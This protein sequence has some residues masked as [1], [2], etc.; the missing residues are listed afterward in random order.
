MGGGQPCGCEGC[1]AQGVRRGAGGAGASDPIIP[2]S[3]SLHRAILKQRRVNRI[4]RSHHPTDSMRMASLDRAD[5]HNRSPPALLPPPFFACLSACLLACQCS[6][7]CACA[8]LPACLCWCRQGASSERL[9]ALQH[10]P[11]RSFCDVGARRPYLEEEAKQHIKFCRE[12][13][14]AAAPSSPTP[15]R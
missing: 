11:P 3:V 9:L 5:N 14:E 15:T 4:P 1:V 8:C 7:A 13:F 12:A 6:A 10:P 2:L